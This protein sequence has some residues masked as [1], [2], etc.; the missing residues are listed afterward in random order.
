MIGSCYINFMVRFGDTG[1]TRW[2]VLW[3]VG[4]ENQTVSKAELNRWRVQILWVQSIIEVQTQ[5]ELQLDFETSRQATYLNTA[6]SSIREAINLKNMI[7]NSTGFFVTVKKWTG[8]VRLQLMTISVKRRKIFKCGSRCSFDQ[9]FM[10]VGQ[11]KM[12]ESGGHR[13]YTKVISAWYEDTLHW[14]W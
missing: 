4:A 9:K 12:R 7:T 14:F 3:T 13:Y 6:T 1:A 10:Y 11:Q 2:F 8:I 5:L